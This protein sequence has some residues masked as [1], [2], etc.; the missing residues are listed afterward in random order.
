[1]NK[2]DRHVLEFAIKKYWKEKTDEALALSLNV[3][4]EE[5]RAM[6]LKL[7]LNHEKS[8]ETLK[9]FARRYLMELPDIEKRA[10]MKALPPEMI[11][12]MGEG[13]PH[14]SE[15]S[16]VKHVLPTPIMQLN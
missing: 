5:V 16:T 13:N 15:D 2:S 8:N 4:E 14:S 1:M 11:W 10:F 3:T 12:R 9:E 6:R 7:K